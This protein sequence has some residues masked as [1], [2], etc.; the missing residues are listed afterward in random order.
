MADDPIAVTLIVAAVLDALGVPYLVGGSMASTVHGLVRTTL[1]ADMVAQLKVEHVEPLVRALQPAFYIE[2]D[3]IRD[4]IEHHSSFN[5][6]HLDSMFKVDIFVPRGRLYDAAQFAHRTLQTTS[7]GPEHPLYFASAE[8]TVLTKLEWY[9]LGGET[10]ERQ[11]RDVIGVL[12]VQQDR[13]DVPYMRRWAATLGVVDLLERA[14]A[15]AP[16]DV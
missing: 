7:A 9:R 15:E 12:R 1:D 8:D 16:H 2:A 11:W 4:A 3:D 5:V 14:L 10:S 13:L 6:I